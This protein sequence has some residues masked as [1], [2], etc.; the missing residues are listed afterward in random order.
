MSGQA[1]NV[2]FVQGKSEIK[3]I[4]LHI[5]EIG[6]KEFK[7]ILP[8]KELTPF[9]KYF[10]V[11]EDEYENEF[12][13]RTLPIG[14]MQLV[15]HMGN[16]P[17]STLNNDYQPKAC[18]EG[19]LSSFEDLTHYGHCKQVVAMF[20]PHAAQLF[21]DVPVH[22]FYNRY[23]SI[24]ELNDKTLI[25]LYE[26][27]LSISDKYLTITLIEEF[28]TNRISLSNNFD[29]MCFAIREIE[30]INQISIKQLSDITCLSYKQFNR[31][32]LNQTGINPKEFARTIR[33]QKAMSYLQANRLITLTRLAEKCGFYDEPH[34]L[35]EFKLFTGYTPSEYIIT[36]ET[37]SD[38]FYTMNYE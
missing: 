38:Y 19:H 1:Q 28:L 18:I 34:L 4:L 10:W 30:K 5:Y 26:K 37:C 23:T 21:F 22:D 7:V 20:H 29:R 17:F 9:V 32:F 15:F 31:I 12:I 14:C 24:K 33:F 13:E 16:P 36:C 3:N 6:V 25:E 27:I 11:F 2:L 8:R 35:R